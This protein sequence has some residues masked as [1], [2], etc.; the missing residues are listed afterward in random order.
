[1]ATHYGG[2]CMKKNIRKEMEKSE[3]DLEYE[4]RKIYGRKYRRAH[5]KN[6]WIKVMD[7]NIAEEDFEKWFKS[8]RIIHKKYKIGMITK[9]EFEDYINKWNEQDEIVRQQ[10]DES[11]ILNMNSKNK[12]KYSINDVLELDKKVYNRLYKRSERHN[13]MEW[14]D[15][16]RAINNIVIKDW[17][18]GNI[19]NDSVVEWLQKQEF[20]EEER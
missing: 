12:N 18:R 4:F 16:W 9:E 20:C 5:Y 8:A 2:T 13:K 3:M 14:F 7:N 10:I 15:T 17:R 11:I 1:M 6:K 19:S